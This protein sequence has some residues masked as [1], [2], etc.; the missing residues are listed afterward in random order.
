MRGWKVT[1][2]TVGLRVSPVKI[3][4]TNVKMS[5]LHSLVVT[6]PFSWEY[7]Y[8]FMMYSISPGGT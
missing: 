8:K 5:D 1:L 3:P 2:N 6:A 4:L 7:N